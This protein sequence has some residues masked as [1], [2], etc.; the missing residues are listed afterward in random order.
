MVRLAWDWKQRDGKPWMD[1]LA[2]QSSKMNIL[3]SWTANTWPC[4]KESVSVHFLF[5]YWSSSSL[6]S[7]QVRV[8][9]VS[10]VVA[11]WWERVLQSANN[12]GGSLLQ[13]AN[14]DRCW[15]V[16]GVDVVVA[17]QLRGPNTWRWTISSVDSFSL[18]YVDIELNRA[19]CSG[20]QQPLQDR[21]AFF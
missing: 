14:K 21:W 12:G 5:H 19:V 13:V 7:V 10:Q 2:Q 16:N 4:A 1:L 20:F 11:L 6:P 8:A 17:A 3:P 9:E 15:I 18:Y